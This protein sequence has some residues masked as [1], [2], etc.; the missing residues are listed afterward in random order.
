MSINDD[1]GFGRHILPPAPPLQAM[2]SLQAD[3]LN[4]EGW[5]S[6]A[7][8]ILTLCFLLY[9]FIGLNPF[10]ATPPEAR[11]EGSPA[12]RLIVLAMSAVALV[13]L[14]RNRRAAYAC[15]RHN[16]L[17]FSMIAFCQ[18]SVF[19]SDYPELTIRRAILA[20]LASVI[21]T[22][23][24]IS[25]RSLRS[26]H[27][28]LFLALFGVVLMN[29]AV[30]A[31]WPSFAISDIGVN[32][33]YTQKNVAGMVAMITLIICATWIAGSTSPSQIAF[34]VFAAAIV[35]F[36]LV[37]TSSK[38][39]IG[40]AVLALAVGGIFWLA[41]IFGRPFIL[42]ILALL[43]LGIAAFL[44][45]VV[46]NDYDAMRVTGFFLK[47]TSFSG[48]DELWE[49]AWRKASERMWLGHGY[50]AFWD[51]GE[52]N[53]PLTRLE[54]GTWLGDVKKGVINQA[55]NGY[56]ELWL[57]IGL[58]A[59]CLVVIAIFAGMISATKNAIVSLPAANTRATYA[60]I[61]LVLFMHLVHNLTEATLFMRGN[62][63]ATLVLIL[64]LVGSSF[65][66][67]RTT[68]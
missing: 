36:F 13:I 4:R 22:A 28:L 62:Q 12:D 14:L 34:G 24:A 63:F 55:H 10:G 43:T 53:D 52:V 48:R 6:T 57:H 54:P 67:A 61:A 64:L 1:A 35:A 65:P 16:L 44:I 60:A 25:V 17:I 21:A 23:I 51:V 37:I 7:S 56:L 20:L 45:L 3:R 26:F 32:G 66:R 58:P 31:L 33:I 8:W 68:T 39:S 19:W 49:F 59:T 5:S 46:A 38:T 29:L 41:S 27:T 42:F 9:T 40:I 15:V 18:V 47:D 30:T 50:G 11:V 2:P